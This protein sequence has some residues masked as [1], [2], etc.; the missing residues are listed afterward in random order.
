[1]ID[2][3]KGWNYTCIHASWVDLQYL[4]VQKPPKIKPLNYTFGAMFLSTQRMC[5]S[6]GDG[7]VAAID[8]A[9]PPPSIHWVPLRGSV[10]GTALGKGMWLDKQYEAG[11]YNYPLLIVISCMKNVYINIYIYI[12]I[13]LYIYIYICMYMHIHACIY[14]YIY[15]LYIYIYILYI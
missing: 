7:S 6:H 13:Y 8:E 5:P 4:V 2:H 1:M 14:I 11:S 12:S 15:N 9:A 3:P 10:W